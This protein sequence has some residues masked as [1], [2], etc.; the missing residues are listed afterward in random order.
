[1]DS[2]LRLAQPGV[3]L[4]ISMKNDSSRSDPYKTRAALLV[5]KPSPA[6]K[7]RSSATIQFMLSHPL[8]VLSFG[9]GSGLSPVIPGTLGTLFGW[10][11]FTVLNTYLNSMQW[12]V[13]IASSLAAGCGFTGFTARQMSEKD[14]GAV[15]WDEIV[16]IW[17]VMLFI[18]PANFT[19]QLSAFLIFRFF[20]IA[21]PPPIRYFNR[22]LSGG[23]DIM[24]DDMIAAL[25][26]LIVIMMAS[27]SLIVKR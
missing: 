23:F 16:A 22:R 14:P 6:T 5:T 1:M 2:A 8:H 15:V 19:Y 11:S 24:L 10:M 4:I 18:T 12:W 13:L 3:A 26:T 20:D 9:F 7:P 27:L 25:L 21:K 17:V